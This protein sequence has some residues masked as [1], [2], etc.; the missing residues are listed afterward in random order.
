MNVNT[1]TFHSV[2]ELREKLGEQFDTEILKEH[3]L[4]KGHDFKIVAIRKNQM[5]LQSTRLDT[6][7][8]GDRE[9]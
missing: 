5:V 3:V 2:R 8:R 1:G 6:Q 4:F 7:K 9:T